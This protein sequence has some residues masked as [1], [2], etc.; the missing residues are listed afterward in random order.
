[1]AWAGKG[2]ENWSE[3]LFRTLSFSGF[4]IGG[5]GP[6]PV[7]RA[8]SPRSLLVGEAGK[9]IPER[10]L[11]S[12]P[13]RAGTDPAASGPGGHEGRADKSPKARRSQPDHGG[14]PVSRQG[15]SYVLVLYTRL[16]RGPAPAS[17]SEEFYLP[18]E[19][20]PP[21]PPPE[22]LPHLL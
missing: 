14:G 5:K 12:L 15:R 18:R 7:G 4:V 19:P 2:T 13:L 10:T 17:E 6:T 3:N 11:A 1:M 21:F 16:S 22:A 9:E 20:E 8:R